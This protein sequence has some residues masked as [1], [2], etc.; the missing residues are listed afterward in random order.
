MKDVRGMATEEV[1]K[2]RPN[3]AL[4]ETFVIDMKPFIWPFILYLKALLAVKVPD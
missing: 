1:E 2:L 4:A 3:T